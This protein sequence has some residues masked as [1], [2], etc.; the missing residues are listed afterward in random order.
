[1]SIRLSNSKSQHSFDHHPHSYPRSYFSMAVNSH[2]P[3]N[4]FFSGFMEVIHINTI[5]E[6]VQYF[7]SSPTVF[8]IRPFSTLLVKPYF[9]Q[10]ISYQSIT[11]LI[12]SF[13]PLDT[14][15][16]ILACMAIW[17]IYHYIWQIFWHVILRLSWLYIYIHTF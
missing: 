7:I 9:F 15:D 12:L 1:M 10:G 2:F 4:T 14:P 17:Q 16:C 3:G 5:Y 11:R 8:C 13:I 6:F